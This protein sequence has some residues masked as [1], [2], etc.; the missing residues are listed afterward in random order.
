M[1]DVYIIGLGAQ[2]TVGRTVAST[3]AAIGASLSRLTVHPK[4]VDSHGELVTVAMASYLA[5]DLPVVDRMVEL[6]LPAINEALGL[7]FLHEPVVESAVPLILGL[8]NERPGHPPTFVRDVTAGIVRGFGRSSK[9]SGVQTVIAGHSA[10]LIAIEQAIG[11]IREGQCSICLAGGCDS[12]IAPDTLRWLDETGRLRSNN[13]ISG[14]FPGEGA[15]FCL[16]A[17]EEIDL[18]KSPFARV[19]A[20]ATAGADPG[21]SN[22]APHPKKPSPAWTLAM[23][24]LPE[25]GEVSQVLCDLNGQKSRADEFRESLMSCIQHFSR[26]FF[27]TSPALDWGD[28]GAASGP[29][30]VGLT[31]SPE[32]SVQP[33]GPFGLVS[34]TSDRGPRSALLLSVAAAAR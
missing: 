30:L 21:S 29:L 2:T 33:R 8:P 15:G 18:A 28:V 12:Y 13:N 6:A 7:L 23:E 26:D 34:T 10:G 17:S 20:I 1:K 14:F 5:E 3:S 24:S 31:I 16:L 25:E 4:A 9:I 22:G 19:V 11:M 27:F 32:T